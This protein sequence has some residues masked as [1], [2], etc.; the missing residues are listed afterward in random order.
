MLLTDLDEGKLLH[1]RIKHTE[2]MQGFPSMLELGPVS[3]EQILI[4]ATDSLPPPPP[5]TPYGDGDA[6]VQIYNCGVLLGH[7]ASTE[8]EKHRGNVIGATDASLD[9]YPYM[10]QILTQHG[11]P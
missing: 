7:S 11:W 4:T 3:S 9:K 10:T 1:V 2:C 8:Y 6:S 5:R